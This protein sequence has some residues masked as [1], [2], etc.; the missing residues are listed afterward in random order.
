MIQAVSNV[1][2]IKD[3]IAEQLIL[4]SGI[5]KEFVRESTYGFGASLDKRIG[6]QYSTVFFG[7][8]PENTIIL[9]ALHDSGSSSGEFRQTSNTEEDGSITYYRAYRMH[10]VIYGDASGDVSNVL[11]ARFRT[12]KV[13]R[14]LYEKGIFVETVGDPE[15]VHEIKNGAIWERHDFDM[16]IRCRFNIQQISDDNDFL[17]I[18]KINTYFKT[19]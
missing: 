10:V 11:A 18:G 6:G 19:V 5:S 7:I 8:R 2:E 1:Q 9:F 4:Q 13:I 15:E 16:N 3:G 14:T 17:E 12:Q